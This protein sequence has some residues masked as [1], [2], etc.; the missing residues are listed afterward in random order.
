MRLL[1]DG[2][3]LETFA[4]VTGDGLREYLNPRNPRLHAHWVASPPDIHEQY[5][6]NLVPT[7]CVV[8]DGHVLG[9]TTDG[10]PEGLQKLLADSGI[11]EA[12]AG[13][14]VG[15]S[16]EGALPLVHSDGP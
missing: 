16:G 15:A 8:Q 11:G 12:A 1:D 13:A 7:L 6:V 5:R 9:T 4:L 2:T 10:S 3:S 14:L